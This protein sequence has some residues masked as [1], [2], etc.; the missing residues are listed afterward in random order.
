MATVTV[1]P[2][3][4]FFSVSGDTVTIEATYSNVAN[5]NSTYNFSIKQTGA[6]GD[7]I[8]STAFSF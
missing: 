2:A 4:P 7:P 6:T 5:Y 1:D 8:R 3:N